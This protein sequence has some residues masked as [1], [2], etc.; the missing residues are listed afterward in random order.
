[1]MRFLCR[2]LCRVGAE[3]GGQLGER[4]AVAADR[5]REVSVT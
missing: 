5:G 4:Q 1:M 3:P 2:N